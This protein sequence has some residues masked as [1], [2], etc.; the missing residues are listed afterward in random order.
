MD[1]TTGAENNEAAGA[2]S[3]GERGGVG[4]GEG[5]VV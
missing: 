5:G 3:D 2:G 4:A 1:E